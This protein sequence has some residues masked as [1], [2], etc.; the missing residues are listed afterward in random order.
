MTVSSLSICSLV[1][2]PPS[3]SSN[4][5]HPSHSPFHDTSHILT[6]IFT[7][8]SPHLPPCKVVINDDIK[9][10]SLYS[11]NST[12]YP[13]DHRYTLVRLNTLERLR[14]T[15]STANVYGKATRT[16]TRNRRRFLVKIVWASCRPYGVFK[17][18]IMINPRLFS[19][20][21]W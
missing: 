19:Q 13:T 7:F 17:L 8:P 16:R 4:C 20:N 14:L 10:H 18:T 21:E 6:I 15:T 12:V 11:R 3:T 1:P 9:M 5:L 2:V